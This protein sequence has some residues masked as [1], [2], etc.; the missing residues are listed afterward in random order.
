MTSPNQPAPAGAFVIGGGE[1]A[2]GQDYTKDIVESLFKLPSIN[3]GNAIDLLRDQLLK[4]PL[5]A[6]KVFAPLIPDSIEKDFTSVVKAVTSILRVLTS[7]PRSFSWQEWQAWIGNTFNVVTTELRQIMEILAGLIVTPINAAVQAVKD[8]WAALMGKTSRL[9]SEG[10]LDAANL[11]GQIA[12][13]A[14]EGLEQLAANVV[15][16]FKAVVNGWTGGSGATGT[17]QEVKYTIEQIKDAVI[18]GYNVVTFTTSQTNW[19]KPNCTEFVAVLIGGGENGATG[20]D[21]PQGPGALGGLHGSYIVQQFVVSGLP[22]AFDIQVGTAGN[23]SYL[24]AANG[25]HTGTLLVDS[26]PHGS[27][28]GTATAFGYAGTASQPGSGGFGAAGGNT[29]GG[30]EPTP[31]GPGS[32]STAAAGGT[33]GAAGKDAGNGGDGGPGGNVSAAA[34]TKCGGGG[35]GGGGRGG[36][37]AA[38]QRAGDGGKGGPGGYPGGGGGAGGGR[39]T[40]ATYGD[41]SQG[42]GGPGAT[43]VVWIFY[44]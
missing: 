10:K 11:V 14:V 42:P 6:L 26:G 7:V 16:G 12:K 3:A 5:E 37:G 24:R 34:L 23:R 2:Y 44:R 17:P 28:G 4:L 27:L 33:A 1:L 41:G 35:G 21:G 8:F 25:S 40:N 13:T 22:A 38:F 43:G 19:P 20:V 30:R 32:P 18:S 15:D 31:G 39:G 36:G 29:I 9:S